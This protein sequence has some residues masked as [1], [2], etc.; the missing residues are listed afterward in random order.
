MKIIEPSA[1]L[2]NP[3]TNQDGIQVL[4]FIE[5]MARIS[6]NSEEA[7]TEDSWKRFLEAVVLSHGDWSVVEHSVATVIFK[8]DRGCTHE[9]VRHRLFSYTQSSTRFINYLKKPIEFIRPENL[10]DSELDLWRESV[11]KSLWTYEQM[12]HRKM[13]PQ[14]ARSVLPNALAA[15]I[16]MTGNLRNWRHFFLMRSSRETHPDLRRVVVPLL[17]T[18]QECIPLLFDDIEPLAR[19]IDNLKKAR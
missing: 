18:F 1:E 4:R 10:P 9:I 17:K 3:K 2:I 5:G 14:L 15:T 19:Q 11:E 12:L 7:Q 6:H 8:I 16:S 13:S